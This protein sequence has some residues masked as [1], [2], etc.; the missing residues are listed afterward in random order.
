MVAGDSVDSI[1]P[2]GCTGAHP[3]GPIITLYFSVC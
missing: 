3:A 1:L 2:A